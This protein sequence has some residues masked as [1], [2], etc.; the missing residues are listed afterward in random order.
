MKEK[1][2]DVTNK[3]ACTFAAVASLCFITGIAILRKGQ[4]VNG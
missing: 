4:V 1:I 3:L 2:K